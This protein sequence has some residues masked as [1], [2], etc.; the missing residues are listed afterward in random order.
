MPRIPLNKFKPGVDKRVLIFLSGLLWIGVGSAL[1]RLSAGW[2]SVEDNH[3]VLFAGLGTTAGLIIHHFGFLRVVDKNLGRIL[4][5]RGKHCVFSFMSWK[6]YLI[7][8]IMATMGALL[9][10]SPIPKPYL[11]IMYIGIGLSLILSSARYLRVFIT[12]MKTP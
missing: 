5:M 1:L 4:P 8:L 11:S 12:Q 2:L 6:S 7:V 9:R 10:H 3:T